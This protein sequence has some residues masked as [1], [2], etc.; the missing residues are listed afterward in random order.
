MTVYTNKILDE[1]FDITNNTLKKL[2]N[3]QKQKAFDL[4]PFLGSE[5]DIILKVW[6]GVDKNLRQLVYDFCGM[7]KSDFGDYVVES[8]INGVCGT[9]VKLALY[10]KGKNYP[11]EK[12][13]TNTFCIQSSGES[14]TSFM[15]RFIENLPKV[16][17]EIAQK[18]LNEKL[19][20][21]IEKNK[22]NID[23]KYLI[24]N[25]FNLDRSQTSLYEDFEWFK[26]T[27][28]DLGFNFLFIEDICKKLDNR[29]S[30]YN[31]IFKLLR[32]ESSEIKKTMDFSTIYLGRECFNNLLTLKEQEHEMIEILC[33]EARKIKENIPQDRIFSFEWLEQQ[34]IIDYDYRNS[35]LVEDFKNIER[36]RY[37]FSGL[38]DIAEYE[39]DFYIK[40]QATLKEELSYIKRAEAFIIKYYGRDYYRFLIGTKEVFFV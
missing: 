10:A 25:W 19:E 4:I 15:W 37:Y 11:Y 26:D 27:F 21:I 14:I 24:K 30:F 32:Y 36:K 5:K 34:N 2:S 23:M 40:T 33:S 16:L 6:L 12:I 22:N 13:K 38:I 8:K 9:T 20:K 1:M 39:Y 35:S 28:P 29:V 7:T 17:S 18:W 31:A 3:N